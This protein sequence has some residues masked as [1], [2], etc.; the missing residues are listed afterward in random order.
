MG[1]QHSI[2]HMVPKSFESVNRIE[3]KSRVKHMLVQMWIV[4]MIVKCS[5]RSIVF[6]DLGV[7]LS[8]RHN[9]TQ[10]ISN[11]GC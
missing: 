7:T 8:Y 6:Y 9:V 4:G 11:V 10:Y 2:G 1:Y 3:D 5:C